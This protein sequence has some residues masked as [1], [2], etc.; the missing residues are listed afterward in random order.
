M[1][2]AAGILVKPIYEQMEFLPSGLPRSSD[3]R[4][5]GLSRL[6]CICDITYLIRETRTNTEKIKYT[7]ATTYIKLPSD[8]KIHTSSA[9]PFI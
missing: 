9:M 2:W 6:Y 4:G 3:Y 5:S 7:Y 8:H 1:N